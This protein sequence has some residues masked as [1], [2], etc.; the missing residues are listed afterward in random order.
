MDGACHLMG[1]QCLFPVGWMNLDASRYWFLTPISAQGQGPLNGSNCISALEHQ[2]G[3]HA[4]DHEVAVGVLRKKTH[5]L[6]RPVG[7]GMLG[8]HL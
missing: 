1:P 8:L 4:S 2:D 6:P 7:E 5:R 3:Y